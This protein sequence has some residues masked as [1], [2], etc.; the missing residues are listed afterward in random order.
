[1]FPSLEKKNQVPAIF[2]SLTYRAREAIAG[3]HI[4]KHSYDQGVEHSI[5][6]LDKLYL[7][8]NQHSAYEAYEQFEKL[9]RP[10]LINISN[11]IIESECLQNKIE[12]VK[13]LT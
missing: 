7:K 12:N 13:I 6:E 5:Q 4:N 9:C 3:L 8:D 2:W 1:M 11:H 10:K